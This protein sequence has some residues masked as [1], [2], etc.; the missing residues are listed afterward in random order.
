MGAKNEMWTHRGIFLR[1]GRRAAY[2]WVHKPT[3]AVVPYSNH[4]EKLVMQYAW[5]QE[6]PPKIAQYLL[7]NLLK[8]FKKVC[9]T[10]FLPG[11]WPGPV[12]KSGAGRELGK[13][14]LIDLR[15]KKIELQSLKNY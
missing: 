8:N 6:K 7:K 15:Y 12:G 13:S 10:K 11:P 2:R 5:L 4:I 14:P 9:L 1:D 3:R